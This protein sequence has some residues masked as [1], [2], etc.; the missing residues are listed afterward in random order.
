MGPLEVEVV[1]GAVVAMFEVVVDCVVA[2]V[3]GVT[4]PDTGAAVVVEVVG[5]AVAVDVVGAAV[6]VVVDA[7]G[8]V[9]VVVAAGVK[10]S[11]SEPT[12]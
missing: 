12:A 10:F 2:E 3:A 8:V 11:A 9:T 4:V 1:T 7:A 6:V 5:A